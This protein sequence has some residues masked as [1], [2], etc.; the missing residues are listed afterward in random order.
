MFSDIFKNKDNSVLNILV[1]AFLLFF[2]SI[3]I[4]YFIQENA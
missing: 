1:F 4:F 3:L 2:Y